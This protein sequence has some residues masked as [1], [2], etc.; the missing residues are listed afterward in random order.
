MKFSCVIFHIFPHAVQVLS[1]ATHFS[2]S[3]I[4]VLGNILNCL[5]QSTNCLT[6][7]VNYP[8]DKMS[9]VN[10]L[11]LLKPAMTSSC[12]FWKVSIEICVSARTE[13]VL[14]R[15]GWWVGSLYLTD[16]SFPIIP[17]NASWNIITVSAR[18]G[19]N[20]VFLF[21]VCPQNTTHT[22]NKV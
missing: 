19:L 5:V 1:N 2:G 8:S 7:L 10:Q 9:T 16:G 6:L 21:V 18:I 13:M 15:K 11:F 12:H 4:Y 17:R 3:N 22:K 20:F 14:W